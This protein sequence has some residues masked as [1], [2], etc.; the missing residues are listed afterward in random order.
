MLCRYNRI[1][2]G[3]LVSIL[4]LFSCSDDVSRI[5]GYK[6]SISTELSIIR[7]IYTDMQG[8][9]TEIPV[10]RVLILPF[11]KIE[12]NSDNTDT[13]FQPVYEAAK[14]IDLDIFPAY[15]TK[16]AL[17]PSR[18]YKVY[19]IGYK[20]DDFDF[21]NPDDPNSSF[22]IGSVNHPVTLDNFHLK[23]TDA[24]IVP[25]LFISMCTA[26]S[27][28][29]PVTEYFQPEQIVRLKGELK[30]IV[31]SVSVNIHNIP[32]YITSI[33]LVADQLVQS[34]K[35]T[36]ASATIWQTSGEGNNNV[37]AVKTSTTGSVSFNHFL[38]PTFDEYKTRF[39]LDITYGSSTERYTIKVPDSDN[40]SVNDNIIFIPNHEVRITGNY[41]SINAGF[42]INNSINLD[43]DDWDGI[44]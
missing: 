30:R 23:T 5:E 17:Q 21:H 15:V 19:I 13:N 18:T 2:I 34:I 14:Q 8:N 31:S 6:E 42:T 43:D 4:M 22:T 44:K 7:G 37:F 26:Y 11:I 32:D 24:T 3:C 41:D 38:M 9:G 39:Y 1:S 20:R 12:E 40:V 33:S 36:D 35:L 28:E 10:E 25:E 27:D 16:L 29:S